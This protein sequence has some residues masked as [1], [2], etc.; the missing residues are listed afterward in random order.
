[1]YA[2]QFKID[3]ITKAVSSTV[4]VAVVASTAVVVSTVNSN[5]YSRIGIILQAFILDFIQKSLYLKVPQV[6]WKI[7]KT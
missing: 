1:M 2:F 6:K 3:L 5:K 7:Y 4:V